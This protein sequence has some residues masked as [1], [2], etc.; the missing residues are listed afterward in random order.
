MCRPIS[1]LRCEKQVRF[2]EKNDFLADEGENEKDKKKERED[3]T[4]L[5]KIEKP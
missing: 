5:L 1:R 3:K 2:G 4:I